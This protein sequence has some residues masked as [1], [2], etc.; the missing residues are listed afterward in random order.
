MS[1]LKRQASFS[2]WQV[3]E[4]LQNDSDSREESANKDSDPLWDIAARL[5]KDSDAVIPI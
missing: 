4:Q 5:D 1:R 2:L 3:F